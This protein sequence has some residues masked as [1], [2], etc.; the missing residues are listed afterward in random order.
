M[1]G[2]G[3]APIWLSLTL[4][5]ELLILYQLLSSLWV[6][7]GNP[8]NGFS[9]SV[10]DL[11]W[12]TQEEDMLHKALSLNL[13][14]IPPGFIIFPFDSEAQ[15]GWPI[16]QGTAMS[17]EDQSLDVPSTGPGFSPSPY[18]SKYTRQKLISIHSSVA[19]PF[20]PQTLYWK[21]CHMKAEI[22]LLWIILIITT[23]NSYGAPKCTGYHTIYFAWIITFTH[24]SNYLIC[25]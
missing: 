16:S 11:I 25:A 21:L 18:C 24:Q 7:L 13:T 5:S 1:H 20:T 6:L 9:L 17:E 23:A 22:S 12:E 2:E 10:S 15:Q 3:L 8:P 19:R 4:F 14:P